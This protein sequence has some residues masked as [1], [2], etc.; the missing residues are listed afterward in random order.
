MT[1]SPRATQ[2]RVWTSL[3]L[4]TVTLAS[5]PAVADLR[6][7]PVTLAMPQARIWLA[8]AEGGEAGEAGITAEAPEDAAYLAELM[9]VQGHMQAARDLYALG[10]KD[11]AVELS[12][13]PE[14]EG[15]LAALQAQIAKNHAQ[16]V[17]DEIAN[18]TDTMAKGASQQDVDAAAAQV[19]QAF[20]AAASVKDTELRARFDAVVLL[21]KAAAGEYQ[22]S[23]TDGKVEDL[24]GWHEAWS[25]IVI[26][27]AQLQDLSGLA[28]TAKA[29]PK[30]LKAL[31]E[32]NAA[33]GDPMAA[34]PL[35]GDAQIVLGVA[36]KLELI[37]SAVR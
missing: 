27:R 11:K 14:E 1:K 35:A 9:I 26:A 3:A 29:A 21:V 8:Q 31:E 2:P 33:F 30:A 10:E 6:P 24:M 13:H 18:L 32:V 7:A 12:K 15:T 37:A 34:T 28:L 20:A 16:D 17:S 25:F 22:A 19:E 5:S 4:A 36:A 23:I